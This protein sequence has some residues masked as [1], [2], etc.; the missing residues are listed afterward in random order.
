MEDGACFYFVI[1][2]ELVP[3]NSLDL[4]Y[5]ASLYY[6]YMGRCIGV[7]LLTGTPMKNGKPSNLF[8]LLRAARHPFGDD[9]KMYEAFFCNGQQRCYGGRSVWDASGCSN[10]GMLN[11]HI[12]SHVLYKTKD[13]CLKELPGKT[14]E[15]KT[16]PVGSKFQIQHNRA[17]SDLVSRKELVI[18]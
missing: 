16:I 18:I 12:S 1:R 8:P 3:H 10:L 5:N 7:L 14:R 4:S 11:A 2:L 9:Q 6:Y 13:E 17:L 15:Y